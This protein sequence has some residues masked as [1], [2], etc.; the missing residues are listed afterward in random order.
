MRNKHDQGAGKIYVARRLFLGDFARTGLAALATPALAAN[1]MANAH[2]ADSRT[3]SGVLYGLELEGALVG[4]VSAVSGGT[5][6]GEL[7]TLKPGPDYIQRKR[8]GGARIEPITLETTSPMAKPFNDWIKS[9][10]EPGA[11]FLRKNGAIVA[12]DPSGKELWRR[13]FSDAVISS[14]QFPACDAA[15]K[16]PAKLS[17]TFAPREVA[18]TSGKGTLSPQAQQSVRVPMRDQ[19]F[20]LRIQG[21]ESATEHVR[22]IDAPTVK[23][24]TALRAVGEKRDYESA[25]STIDVANLAMIVPDAFLGPFY[26]WHEDFVRKGNNGPDRERVGV[27]EYLT[28]DRKSSLLTLNLFNLGIFKIAQE[29]SSRDERPYSKVE[30]YCQAMTVDFKV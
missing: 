19:S 26:A 29:V 11:K 5:Y 7:A 4:R 28:P 10:I 22:E 2:A 14:V 1:W 9:S 17:V 12:A 23:V 24:T 30:M 21:L 16:D 25:P 6:V 18:L 8:I 15:S 13:N 20:R 3:Y 27:L